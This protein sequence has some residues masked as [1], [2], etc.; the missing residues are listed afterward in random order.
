MYNKSMKYISK[1][2]STTITKALSTKQKSQKL[3]TEIGDGWYMEK[4]LRD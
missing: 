1:Q 3:I 4:L 2:I